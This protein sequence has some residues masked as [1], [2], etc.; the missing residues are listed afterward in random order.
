MKTKYTNEQ[1]KNLFDLINSDRTITNK[2]A[3][4]SREVFPL[5]ITDMVPANQT[6]AKEATTKEFNTI[7]YV[8]AGHVYDTFGQEHGKSDEDRIEEAKS[9]IDYIVK[10]IQRICKTSKDPLYNKLKVENVTKKYRVVRTHRDYGDDG[11]DHFGV[12]VYL[13]IA[14]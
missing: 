11:D 14:Y 5:R 10:Q 8:G 7:F 2:L 12:E 13:K 3:Y 6:L 1:I 9:D 4:G